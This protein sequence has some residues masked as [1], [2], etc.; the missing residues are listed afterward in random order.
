MTH[1]KAE[2]TVKRICSAMNWNILSKDQYLTQQIYPAFVWST[3][4]GFLP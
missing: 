3:V 4:S 2:S 1:H